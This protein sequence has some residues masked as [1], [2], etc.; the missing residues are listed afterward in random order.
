M[1]AITACLSFFNRF[2]KLGGTELVLQMFSECSTDDTLSGLCVSRPH[3][4]PE[5]VSLI[6]LALL[7]KVGLT[8]IT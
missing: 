8:V 7:A 4:V 3:Q 1:C 5:I 6:A 2:T